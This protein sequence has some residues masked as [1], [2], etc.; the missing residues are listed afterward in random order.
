[1]LV[2][3]CQVAGP[4]GEAAL[5]TSQDV[6]RAYQEVLVF[7]A[8]KAQLPEGTVPPCADAPIRLQL[9]GDPRLGPAGGHALQLLSRLVRDHDDGHPELL[10]QGLLEVHQ[11]HVRPPRPL[12]DDDAL[13]L[14]VQDCPETVQEAVLPNAQQ[15]GPGAWRDLRRRSP[16]GA[17][18]GVLKVRPPSEVFSALS[19][20]HDV[21]GHTIWRLVELRVYEARDMLLQRHSVVVAHH[22]KG[23]RPQS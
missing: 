6:L 12:A 3:V 9:H 19:P 21:C 4:A 23:Q 15:E 5:L 18:L 1:M 13:R 17:R 16:L 22:A 11:L 8:C 20:V 14:Q 2:Q 7:D 10:E